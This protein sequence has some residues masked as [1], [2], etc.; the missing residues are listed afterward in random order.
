MLAHLQRA[1]IVA[2]RAGPNTGSVD[3]L[4]LALPMDE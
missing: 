3:P 4:E 1:S 2:A